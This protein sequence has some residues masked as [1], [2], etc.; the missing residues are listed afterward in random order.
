MKKLLAS[1]KYENRASIRIY[2]IEHK[3]KRRRGDVLQVEI[4]PFD[5]EVIAWA[6]RPDEAVLLIT[7]LAKSLNRIVAGWEIGLQEGKKRY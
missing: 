1:Y 6:M 3:D 7:L 4:K 2:Y 5:S